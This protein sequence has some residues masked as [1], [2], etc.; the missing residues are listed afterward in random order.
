[1]SRYRG[2]KIGIRLATIVLLGALMIRPGFAEDARS[3]AHGDGKAAASGDSNAARAPSGGNAGG[4]AANPESHAPRGDDSKAHDGAPPAGNET[5]KDANPS[6]P[7]G[8]EMGAIDTSIAP[9]R[10][11]DKKNRIGEGKSANE[12]AAT[13]NLHRRMLSVPRPAHPAVRNAIGVPLPQH[14]EAERHDSAHPN[15]PAIPHNAP[16]GTVVVPGA[17]GSHLTKIE[18]GVDHRQPSANPV[19]TPP[20]ANRGAIS[21]TGLAHRNSGPSQIGGPKTA[22]AGINGTTIRPKH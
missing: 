14:K 11:L 7:G 17:A 12:S 18:S 21:G 8:K 20:A 19:I 13:R 1:M 6:A 15:S 22:T 4:G 16:A 5:A 2:P 10:R 3:G 9:S